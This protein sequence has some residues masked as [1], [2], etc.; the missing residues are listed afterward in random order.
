VSHRRSVGERIARGRPWNEVLAEEAD[1]LR[2]GPLAPDAFPSP[3]HEQRTAAILG[4][5]LG[6][7]FSLCFLT[8]LFDHFAQEPLDLGFLSMPAAPAGLFRWS[9]GLHVATGI[10]A[11]PLL[12]AKLWTVSPR[13]FS[14]PPIRSVAHVVE[15]V[16]LIPLV[17]G[18]IFQL[19]TGV[20]NIAHWI[21]WTFSFPI[22]HY[23]TAWIVIGGLIVHIGAKAA[24]TRSAL[25]R[26]GGTSSLAPAEPL[27]GSPVAAGMSRRGLLTTVGAAVGVVT[28]TTVGQTFR[29]LQELAVLAPRKP[30][31]GPQ[32]LPVNKS[33]AGARVIPAATAADYALVVDGPGAVTPLRLTLDQLRALPQHTA[34]LP[35]ACVE[36]WSAGATWTGVRVRE[37]LAMAGASPDREVVVH[38]LQA[39]G[40]YAKS[41]LNVPHAQH[42]DTL[43]ALTI[44][45]EPLHID[46]G[47]PCRLIGPNRPGVQQTKWVGRLEIT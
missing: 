37:L 14:W 29:P 4:L 46:H 27:R 15:R 41:E 44:G 11:I 20:A 13:L 40:A 3:R 34:D 31:V 26:G 30:S 10:A 39:R 12:L 1:R 23:W 5:L 19:V 38:S 16:A 7:A 18:A 8:G 32:G 6:V 24:I 17:A 45:G 9:Q 28:I 25:R 43:L 42:P 21:P 22:A 35:I 2:V 33:A 36:G 47:Y